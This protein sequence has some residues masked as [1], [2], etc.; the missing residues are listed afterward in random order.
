MNIV[1]PLQ[2]LPI[3]G[4]PIAIASIHGRPQPSPRLASTNASAPAY[5]LGMSA[6]GRNRVSSRIGAVERPARYAS[7][8]PRISDSGTCRP[9]HLRTRH[10]SSSGENASHQASSSTSQPLRSVKSKFVRN[11]KPRVPC[12]ASGSVCSRSNRS[13]SIVSGSTC[14]RSAGI[15]PRWKVSRLNSHGTHT[16][17]TS[18][19][20]GSHARGT[21][22]VSNIVRATSG[23]SAWSGWP[24]PGM[25]WWTR[26]N[27]PSGVRASARST[28][29]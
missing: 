22:S 15:P 11:V 9:R 23:P 3:V 27:S 5:S 16:S 4:R 1:V 20:R 25:R 8:R 29:C 7:M 13:K 12:T 28:A 17:S 2:R 6:V 10:T 21:L 14:N 24:G 19:R 18:S 26:T